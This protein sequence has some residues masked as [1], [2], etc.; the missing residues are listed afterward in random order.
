M[1]G[2]NTPKGV[3]STLYRTLSFTHP[4]NAPIGPPT[5]RAHKRQRLMRFG[6]AG[7]VIDT[8]TELCD[9]PN[10]DCFTVED[11]FMFISDGEDAKTCTQYISNEVK[12]V[13]STMWK[14]IIESRTK[15]EFKAWIDG[16][17]SE[18]VK[19][20]KG[21]KTGGDDE[22][23]EA[24]AGDTAS[25]ENGVPVSSAPLNI[26]T[27]VCLLVCLLFLFACIAL[28]LWELRLLRKDIR[29]ILSELKE[30]QQ[31]QQ[32]QQCNG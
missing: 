17:M 7:F 8:S 26:T 22:Q 27:L 1:A 12:F 3:T 24:T 19:V 16:Y 15:D 4:V 20:L 30:M 32:Q 5:T 9:V 29:V 10:G 25:K 18:C 13:K 11:R 14:R 6:E 2:C 21:D 28:L 31:I 23:I